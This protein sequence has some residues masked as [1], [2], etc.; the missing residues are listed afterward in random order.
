[1]KIVHRLY[2]TDFLKILLL[3]S[4]GLSLLASLID[5]IGN[6]D[7][8]LPSK[9]AIGSLVLY[10][11]LNFPKFFLYLLPMSVLICSLFTFSQAM[12][13]K[14][15]VAIKTAG[16]RLRDLYWPF[17]ICGV[18]ISMA[19]FSVSEVV[20][21]DFSARA[22]DLRTRLKGGS[23]KTAFSEG[24]LWIKDGKGNPVRIE[25]YVPEKKAARGISIFVQG[26]TFLKQTIT[27][28]KAA[29][30][31]GRWVLEKVT[32]VSNET[33]KSEELARMEY[34][35][36]E[37]PE[38][39]S[40]EIKTTDEMGI[41]ELYRYIQR[42]RAAGFNNIKL[43][44]DLNAKVSF[45]LINMFMMLLGISL[46]GRSTAG[47]GLYTAGVGLAISL[48]YW[49]GY[50]FSLSIGYAGIAPPF[51]AAWTVPFAFGSFAVYLFKTLPE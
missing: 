25:L 18:L 44:V 39:F 12:R 49:F 36:L 2:L 23:K 22:A 21:P 20:A 34:H 15:I 17:V 30:D 40:G 9:P 50:T 31:E 4:C 33:G 10:A 1:V 16:G 7:D 32:I 14:E 51:I 6:I 43:L 47:G 13:R 19:A 37:S 38:I 8:F 35:D 26:E 11:V 41:N 24:A 28:K 3:I 48:L 45:P 42:L 29:W 27:A 46:A 5:L